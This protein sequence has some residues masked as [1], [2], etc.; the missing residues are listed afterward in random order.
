VEIGLEPERKPSFHER[1]VELF[2]AH[3]DRV[4]RYLNRLSG[5]PELAQDV[6]QEA[7][8]KL[9]RRGSLPDSPE[10]WLISVALNLF[11]NAASSRSRRL[12]LLTPARGEGVHSDPPPSPDQAMEA[13]D[14]RRRVRTALDRMPER[15]RRM[16]LLRAEGY[17]YRDI[18]GA[19]HLN[20]ASVGVLLA[21]ARRAFRK[22]YEDSYGAP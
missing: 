7:F 8:V 6:A 22:I 2:E 1:F 11:R 13:G 21:R 9:Y 14:S 16:L 4:Y 20:E 3:F 17:S 10:A 19:L 18:A 12:R 5:D 15:E